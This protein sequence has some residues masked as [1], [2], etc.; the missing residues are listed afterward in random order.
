MG[1]KG[2]CTNLPER[3]RVFYHLVFVT[4]DDDYQ[5]LE[6]LMCGYLVFY[7]RVLLSPRFD[8]R[9]VHMVK[10]AGILPDPFLLRLLLPCFG[11]LRT[12]T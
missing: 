4:R 1:G 12:A 10:I 9:L 7:H 3:D 11:T 2:T 5:P 6:R 8:I